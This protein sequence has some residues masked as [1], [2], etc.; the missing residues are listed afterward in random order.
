MRRDTLGLQEPLFDQLGPAGLDGEVRLGEGDL[1]LLGIT[2]LRDQVAGVAGEHDV[3]DF[4]LAARANIDHFADVGKMVGDFMSRDIASGFRLRHD[5]EKIVPLRVAKQLLKI[6]G[7]P[8]FDA[9]IG[10]LSVALEGLRQR[11]N[12]VGLHDV[13]SASVAF[14]EF[15]TFSISLW[16]SLSTRAL[17]SVPI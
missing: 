13:S 11:M 15:D 16:N 1:L 2:V 3:I 5:V 17:K 14:A 9:R 6:S 4:P 7:E 12:Q 8:E 10:L